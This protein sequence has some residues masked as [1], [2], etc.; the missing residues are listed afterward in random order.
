M[1]K[2]VQKLHNTVA[3]PAAKA[4]LPP[5][6]APTQSNSAI[7][8]LAKQKSPFLGPYLDSRCVVG[9]PPKR[10]LFIGILFVWRPWVDVLRYLG[11][12]R[13]KQPAIPQVQ[14]VGLG[15]IK[16]LVLVRRILGR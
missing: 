14:C 12:A 2:A 5:R 9:H 16:R 11:K 6:F 4:Q 3:A 8:C 13:Q 10:R 15:A 1:K 7:I